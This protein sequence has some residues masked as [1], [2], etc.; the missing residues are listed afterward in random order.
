MNEVSLKELMVPENPA[1]GY[2]PKY[3]VYKEEMR[4]RVYYVT[5]DDKGRALLGPVSHRAIKKRKNPPTG[6]TLVSRPLKVLIDDEAMR[7]AGIRMAD[8]MNRTMQQLAESLG[9]VELPKP[10]PAPVKEKG[11][12]M[13]RRMANWV[14]D[15]WYDDEWHRGA[16]NTAGT[17]LLWSFTA[18]ALLTFV[19]GAL[20]VLSI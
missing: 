2:V 12:G 14:E 16:R 9:T 19:K 10:E 6:P 20:W 17:V 4:G 3:G 13:L 7:E 11:P 5:S 8:S 15:K 18:L 1:A